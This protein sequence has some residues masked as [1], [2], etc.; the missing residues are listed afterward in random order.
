MAGSNSSSEPGGPSEPMSP[1]PV[2]SHDT[3]LC[4]VPP[5]HLW[6]SA[7]RLRMLYDKAYEKWP[8]HVNLIYPFVAIESLP[9]AVESIAFHLKSQSKVDSKLSVVLNAADVFPHRH[10]NTIF[11]YDSDEKRLSKLKEIRNSICKK[12]SNLFSYPF[13][14]SGSTYCEDHHL[15][16]NVRKL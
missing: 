11:I 2:G 3:A 13:C 6:T 15:P 12:F 5:K 10:D 1:I 14:C 8:P 16:P 4:I 7:D 9:D